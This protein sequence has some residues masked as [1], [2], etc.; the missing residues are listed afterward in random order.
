[1]KN[2]SRTRRANQ[3]LIEQSDSDF[4][5]EKLQERLAKLAGGVA[6]I[7]VG[8]GHRDRNERGKTSH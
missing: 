1:M 3:K 5:K 8:R 7:K 2:Y 4:D 6:I